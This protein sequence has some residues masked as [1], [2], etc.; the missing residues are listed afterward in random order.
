MLG[1]TSFYASTAHEAYSLKA[2]DK[3]TVFEGLFLRNSDAPSLAM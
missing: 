3:V 1:K 2:K